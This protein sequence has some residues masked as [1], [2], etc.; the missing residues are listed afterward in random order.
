MSFDYI[1]VGAGSA[2]CALAHELVQ[3]GRTVLLLEAGGADRSPL[4]KIPAGAWRVSPKHDWGY[5]SQPDPSRH[6]ATEAW[7]RGRVLG[8]TS[9]INGMVYVW[10]AAEDFDRWARHCE[11]RGGWSA[12]KIEPIFRDLENTDRLTPSRGQR[13]P[14]HVRTVK[15]PHPLTE[16]FV[17]SAC[18]AGYPLNADYNGERQDGV[19]YLQLTQHRGLRC[20]AADAF[21]KPLL[22]RKNLKLLLNASVE[23][24]EVTKGRVTAVN[25]QHGGK[26]QREMARDIVLSAGVINSPKLLML[27]GIGDPQELR[28]HRID[29]V[30]DLPGVG[31]N[32]KEHPLLQLDYRCRISSH[33]LTEGIWQKLGI[34]AKYLCFREGPIA[35]AYEAAA[36]LRIDPLL[37]DAPDIQVFFAPIGFSGHADGS[38]RLAPYPAFKVCIIYSHPLSS[39]QI[40]L[41]SRDPSDPPLIECRLLENPRDVEMLVKSIETVRRI[42]QSNPIADLIEAEVT[43]GTEVQGAEALSQFI[44]HHTDTTCQPI[45]TCRMGLGAD[46]VVGPDLRVHGTENLWI[47]DSSIMPDHLSA[48]TNA[49]CMMIGAKLGKQLAARP[50]R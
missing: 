3:S 5:R 10:G 16:A 20:S 2:G 12:R 36:F 42:M 22:G 30:L 21:L 27:S 6:G 46:A 11:G 48:N 23:K 13:G 39:G 28:R 26:A 29:V 35:T 41:A 34:A 33:N 15:R 37:S 8:G 1:I 32:L 45:G 40:R 38:L 31:R 9:S 43:P 47:A 19:G 14:L 25:F 24:I 18:E 44:R 17:R 7:T 49:T 4:I 50:A